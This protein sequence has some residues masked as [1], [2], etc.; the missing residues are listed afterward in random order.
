MKIILV[1]MGSTGDVHPFIA[2]GTVLRRRGHDVTVITSAVFKP[3]TQQAGL[4]FVPVG[5]AEE[6]DLLRQDSKPW[7]SWRGFETVIKGILRV[8]PSI[9]RSIQERYVPGNTIMAAS[10][11]AFGARIAQESLGVPLTTIHLQ[12][13]YFHSLYQSPILHASLS[14]I[15]SLPRLAKHG[16]FRLSHAFA[17]WFVGPETNRFRS[18][19]GLPPARQFVNSWLHS[20]QRVIG[21]FPDWFGP[22]QPDWP[23]QTV[24]TGFPLYDKSEV[25]TVPHNVARFLDDGDPPI[26]FT[27]GSARLALGLL[28]HPAQMRHS[29]RFL[30]AS[31]EACQ[32][33]GRR[34][35]LLTPYQDQVPRRL[36]PGSILQVRTV[37][38]AAAAVCGDRTPRRRWDTRARVCRG[39]AATRH[40]DDARPAESSPF[41]VETLRDS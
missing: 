38:P 41:L 19:F 11:L 4:Q 13:A 26:A 12:P 25:Q 30:K 35:V 22:P 37:Q 23:P 31:V 40:A 1:P 27:P 5:T 17:D 34:G 8:T 18:Q 21:L 36:P 9:Y 2:I 24:L 39:P 14:T 32:L 15:N 6:F 20:P 29:Q 33:L 7:N 10:G 28:R 3:L 16:L